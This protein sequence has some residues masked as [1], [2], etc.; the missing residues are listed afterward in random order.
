MGVSFR[1]RKQFR[2]PL[3]THHFEIRGDG[4]P[5]VLIHGVGASLRI[6]ERV[7]DLLEDDFQCVCYDLRGHGE[8]SK[9][10]PPYTL[11][12]LTHDLE[13]LR[14][15]LEIDRMHIA[16][17][18]VGGMIAPAYALEHPERV[19]SMALLSTAACRTQE[20]KD[21]VAG[22]TEKLESGG[23][24]PLIDLLIDRWFTPEFIKRHPDIIERRK[25]EV[26]ANDQAIFASVFRIYAT[27]EMELFLRE[28]DAPALVMTGENDS[29]CNPR[30]NRDLSGLLRDSELRI[31]P[32]LRHSILLEAPEVVADNLREYFCRQ[33]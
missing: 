30:I 15:R 26:L 10:P 11:D 1:Q 5:L 4:P 12:M 16:G 2:Q 27:T 33:S 8:S 20:E 6:W 21:S 19:M 25:R 24:E 31:L 18:S 32:G 22:L 14:K 17:H 9:P 23:A 28:V 7:V 29:G 13:L 3:H